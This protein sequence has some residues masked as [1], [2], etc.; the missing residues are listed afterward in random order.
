MEGNAI[1]LEYQTTRENAGEFCP[2]R[3]VK[4]SEQACL[5]ED[6]GVGLTN[7][8]FYPLHTY[9]Y[10]LHKRNQAELKD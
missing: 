4:L 2:N 5:D 3:N 10:M 6:E 1:S 7:I 9:P 8:G